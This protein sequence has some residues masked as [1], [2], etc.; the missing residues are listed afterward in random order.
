[1]VVPVEDWSLR[2]SCQHLTLDKNFFLSFLSHFFPVTLLKNFFPLSLS[3]TVEHGYYVI[4]VLMVSS[5]INIQSVPSGMVFAF[6]YEVLKSHHFLDESNQRNLFP[7]AIAITSSLA[8]FAGILVSSFYSLS[9]PLSLCQFLSS[10]YIS[11]IIQD[12]SKT[13]NHEADS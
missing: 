8:S 13:N 2:E 4:L 1:M 5:M 3:C 12:D 6:I 7:R 9:L 11:P 10:A